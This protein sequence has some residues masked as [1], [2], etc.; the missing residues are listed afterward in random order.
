MRGAGP[1]SNGATA[2]DDGLVGYAVGNFESLFAAYDWPPFDTLIAVFD[3]DF[4]PTTK[5]G[6]DFISEKLSVG[7]YLFSYLLGGFESASWV[8]FATALPLIGTDGRT[9]TLTGDRA[10]LRLAPAGGSPPRDSALGVAIPMVS[11]RGG[12]PLASS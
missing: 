1:R 5:S 4:Y 6:L 2:D 12:P 11:G 8:R 3:T 10:E 9:S 7:S